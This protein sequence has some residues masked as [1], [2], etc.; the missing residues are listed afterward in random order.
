LKEIQNTQL[1]GG[2]LRLCPYAQLDDGLLDVLIAYPLSRFQIINLFENARK[3]GSHIYD[4]RVPYYR[5]KKIRVE[6]AEPCIIHGKQI[7]VFL[8]NLQ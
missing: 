8:S 7:F 3:G 1:V 5:C 4:E 2:G 6:F